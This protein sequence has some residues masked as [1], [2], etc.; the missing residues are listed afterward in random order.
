M[1]NIGTVLQDP[2]VAS[3]ISYMF[4]LNFL[5][6]RYLSIKGWRVLPKGYKTSTLNKWMRDHGHVI[7]FEHKVRNIAS[8]GFTKRLMFAPATLGDINE[9]GEPSTATV[10]LKSGGNEQT[11]TLTYGEFVIFWDMPSSGVDNNSYSQIA[12][13]AI[14][15]Y[16]ELLSMAQ[17]SVDNI[18]FWRG[19][20]KIFGADEKTAKEI[21]KVLEA[22]DGRYKAVFS[23]M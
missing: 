17:R 1:G 4:W 14:L 8:D 7:L 19:I 3:P 9:F 18:V 16:A 11:I 15:Y 10:N 21:Q 20:P 22:A 2:K 5:T 6:N 12:Q 23:L 13:T